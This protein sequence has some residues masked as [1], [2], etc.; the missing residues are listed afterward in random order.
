M[1]GV[2]I[3]I[4]ANMPSGSCFKNSKRV[5]YMC[6]EISQMLAETNFDADGE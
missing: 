2:R 4:K 1:R 6:S 5:G 3:C